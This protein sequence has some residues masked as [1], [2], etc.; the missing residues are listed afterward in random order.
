MARTKYADFQ[1]ETRLSNGDFEA[2]QKEGNVQ[3][4]LQQRAAIERTL[5]D[6]EFFR[7]LTEAGEGTTLK[8][9]LIAL[10]KDTKKLIA[11]LEAVRSE[12]GNVWDMLLGESGVDPSRL[13]VL[14]AKCE[15]LNQRVAKRGRKQDFFVGSLLSNLAE[16]YKRA[17]GR[18]GGPRF[19][20]F[21]YAACQRL[22]QRFRPHSEG[23][24]KSRWGRVRVELRG[25]TGRAYTWVGGPYPGLR[26]LRLE[27]KGD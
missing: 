21:A 19:L 17:R 24:L 22:P 23:A 27:K 3:F 11:T 1:P 5:R 10:A 25:G 16:I 20:A 14:L 26:R 7:Q 4:D 13:P 9:A 15:E 8:K 12:P 2:F 6:Y 18:I